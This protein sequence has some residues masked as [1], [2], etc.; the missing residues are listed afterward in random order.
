MATQIPENHMKVMYCKW[1]LYAVAC[2]N[3]ILASLPFSAGERSVWKTPAGK[4]R[5]SVA[6]DCW[7]GT[8]PNRNLSVTAVIIWVNV[9]PYSDQSSDLETQMFCILNNFEEYKVM[10][11]RSRLYYDTSIFLI[12]QLY[13]HP[14]I[15][16]CIPQHRCKIVRPMF[17]YQA[18]LCM[19]LSL[20][21]NNCCFWYFFHF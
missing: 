5:A 16:I 12:N 11:F 8:W 15:V 18:V 13:K 1:Q 6:P 4:S 7:Y 3:S 9:F 2:I 21:Q 20:F 10:Y 14:G 17:R 19:Q